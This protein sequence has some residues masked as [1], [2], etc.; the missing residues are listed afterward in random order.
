MMKD[1]YISPEIQLV[2]FLS[3]EQLASGTGGPAIDASHLFPNSGDSIAETEL[4]HDV[5][6]FFDF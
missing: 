6:L 2:S 4:E 3:R 1:Q 5:P